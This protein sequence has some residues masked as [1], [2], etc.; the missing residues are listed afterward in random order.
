MHWKRYTGKG[1]GVDGSAGWDGAIPLQCGQFTLVVCM[2]FVMPGQKIDAS[3][4]QSW[5]KW[6]GGQHV[7]QKGTLV[8]VR[9]G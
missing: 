8:S 5:L 1:G 6:L 4:L 9:V 7:G 3:T 2:S